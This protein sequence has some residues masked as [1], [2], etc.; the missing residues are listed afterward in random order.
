[1]LFRADLVDQ[2]DPVL[3]AHTA[4]ANGVLVPQHDLELLLGEYCARLGVEVRRGVEV[5]G[6]RSTGADP[7]D[8]ARD[9]DMT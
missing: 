3:A 2:D 1:M 6:V 4:V 7:A 9:P 8:P 5:R